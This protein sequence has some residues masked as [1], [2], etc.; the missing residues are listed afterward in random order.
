[1]LDDCHEAIKEQADYIPTIK[2]LL[3]D[4]RE[5]GYYEGNDVWGK[6]A[7]AAFRRYSFDQYALVY[8]DPNTYRSRK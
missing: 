7:T 3:F 2:E 6:N 1:M 4:L 5:A 8:F